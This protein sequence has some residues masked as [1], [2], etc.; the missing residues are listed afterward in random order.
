M[1]HAT[2]CKFCRKP[3]VLEIDDAYLELGD[4]LKIIPLAACDPCADVRNKISSIEMNIGKL[5]IAL[6]RNPSDDQ[7]GR[8][9]KGLDTL[10]NQYAMAIAEVNHAEQYLADPEFAKW[11]AEKPGQWTQ[12]LS[13]YRQ[14]CRTEFGKKELS[15]R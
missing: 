13:K 1:K 11:L 3:L 4:P 10:C 14:L 8:A 15:Q 9:R 12:I 5:C 2:T 6:C 7:I